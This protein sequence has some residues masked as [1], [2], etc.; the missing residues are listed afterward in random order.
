MKGFPGNSDADTPKH[1]PSCWLLGNERQRLPG[2][3]LGSQGISSTSLWFC[4]QDVPG[5]LDQRLSSAL[6]HS[7]R[8]K[9]WTVCCCNVP[10]A[11]DG[12]CMKQVVRKCF[13]EEAGHA[14]STGNLSSV[15]HVL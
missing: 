4:A 11:W 12:A 3:T 15:M 8:A 5:F 6:E 7:A 1:H 10:W 9:T 2:M 14:H 13:P